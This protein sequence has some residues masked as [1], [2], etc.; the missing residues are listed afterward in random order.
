MRVKS[1]YRESLS[2]VALALAAVVT[3]ALCVL[4]YRHTYVTPPAA[5]VPAGAAYQ[6]SSATPSAAPS[7]APAGGAGASAAA[8]AR[9]ISVLSDSRSAWLRRT[10]ATGHIK[11]YELG[12]V[13]ARPGADTRTI[14]GLVS[15]AA[16]SDWVIVQAGASD[17]H[18]GATPRQTVSGVKSVVTDVRDR[19]PSVIVAL[20]PPSN[21]QP[22]DVLRVNTRLKKWATRQG[23]GVLDTYS[24]VADPN[25]TY[26][27]GLS[28]D[29]VHTNAQGTSLEARAVTRQL[30]SL[31]S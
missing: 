30:P 26:R 14:N 8:N 25:G 9:T 27:S 19:G 22:T 23:I 13:T 31:L 4:A 1:R 28:D 11:G 12:D 15:R 20:V 10:V 21:V 5:A 24:P 29:G 7:A 16:G 3:V 2:V 18:N 17:I 6:A